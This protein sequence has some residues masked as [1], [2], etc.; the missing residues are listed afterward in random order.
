MPPTGRWKAR[1]LRTQPWIKYGAGLL[2]AL[3]GSAFLLYVN[4]FDVP[5]GADEAALAAPAY[6]PARAA[7]ETPAAPATAPEFDEAYF[8][9]VKAQIERIGAR[10]ETRAP[11][12]DA[13][14]ASTPIPRGSAPA[15]EL[16]VITVGADLNVR[17]APR[18]SAP[19]ID[20]LPPGAVVRA[21]GVNADRTWIQARAARAG[22]PGWVYAGLVR[23]VTGR[24]DSL[25]LTDPEPDQE[26]TRHE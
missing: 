12:L 3:A 14:P 10:A 23:L 6:A 22:E 26:R 21:V 11:V 20:S 16:Q 13:T 7:V 5:R 18:I 2:A 15:V 8:R 9:A 4:V 25:P 1:A 17:A 24:L 19:V